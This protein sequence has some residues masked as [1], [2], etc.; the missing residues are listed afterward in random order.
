M[1]SSAKQRHFIDTDQVLIYIWNPEDEVTIRG[2]TFSNLGIDHICQI[3]PCDII[4]I[5]KSRKTEA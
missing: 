4:V 2:I 3:I 1:S 5:P